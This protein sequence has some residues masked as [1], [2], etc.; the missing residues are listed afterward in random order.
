[1]LAHCTPVPTAILQKKQGSRRFGPE[2]KTKVPLP[3]LSEHCTTS[4]LAQQHETHPNQTS[5]WKREFLDKA[6]S[7]FV[8]GSRQDKDR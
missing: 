7:T 3:V 2:F 6:P 4:E 1:M 8:S 5:Q